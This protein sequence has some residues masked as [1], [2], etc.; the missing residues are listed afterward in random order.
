MTSLTKASALLFLTC[1]FPLAACSSSTSPSSPNS[2]DAQAPAE[3]GADDA[4]L[5]PLDGSTSDAELPP[6]DGGKE[7]GLPPI[8]IDAVFRTCALAT[9]CPGTRGELGA[10]DSCT[11]TLLTAMASR[12]VTG[13]PPV[14]QQLSADQLLACGASATSCADWSACANAPYGPAYCATHP[15][16]SCDGNVA[17][18][19]ASTTGGGTSKTCSDQFPCRINAGKAECSSGEACTGFTVECGGNGVVTCFKDIKHEAPCAPNESCAYP[20]APGPHMGSCTRKRVS[21]PYDCAS[22]GLSYDATAT[23]G[24]YIET[25]VPSA[26]DCNESAKCNGDTMRWCI[27]GHART[28]DCGTIGLKCDD[29]FHPPGNCE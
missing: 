9:S 22:V 27:A 29:R 12:A 6:L 16:D 20:P 11:K 24:A 3:A 19:C 8:D 17:V 28:F 5:P 10:V 4:G 14:F 7:A 18:T 1:V 2:P 15:G 25:C 23:T 13:V 21:G 26:P